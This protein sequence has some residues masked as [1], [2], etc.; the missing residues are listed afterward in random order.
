M[1]HFAQLDEANIVTQVIV[2]N[3]AC[4]MNKDGFETEAIGIDFCRSVYGQNTNWLQTSYNGSFR[5]RYAGVGYLYDPQKDVFIVPQPYPSW[6]LD[7]QMTE[8]VAPTPYPDNGN[9]YIWDEP[10][11]SWKLKG[12]IE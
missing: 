12:T 4:C 3:N 6:M 2:I 8:W 11:L 1:A 7:N 9:L 5:G 10:S